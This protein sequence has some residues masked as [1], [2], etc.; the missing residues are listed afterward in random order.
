MLLIY[1]IIACCYPVSSP[2]NIPKAVSHVFLP[3]Y[4][5]HEWHSVR[6]LIRPVLL[7]EFYDFVEDNFVPTGTEV[8]PYSP[9]VGLLPSSAIH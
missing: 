2:S 9:L 7:N 1:W 3:V 8:Q 5:V 6:L 4:L